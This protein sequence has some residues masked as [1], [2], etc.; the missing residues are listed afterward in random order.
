MNSKFDYSL[1]KR[2]GD[3]TGNGV[4]V[5]D[6]QNKKFLY[7]NE[8][9]LNIFEVQDETLQLDSKIILRYLYTEDFDYLKSRSEE[10]LT[11]GSLST[12]EFRL[13]MPNNVTKHLSC[14]VIAF[15]N[16]SVITA[17]V[18]DVSKTKK[19]EDFLIKYT[20]QKDIM[21]DMLTHNLSG[22][23]QLSKDVI[24]SMQ[25]GYSENKMLDVS[26]LI[27]IMQ[28]NTQQCIDI[29][30]DFLRE[31]HFESSLT[32]VRKTRFDVIDK[33]NIML[34][35]LKEINKE[36][37]FVLK[38][39]LENLYINSDAVKFFQIIHNVLSNSIKFT[40]PNGV[41]EIAV[42][43]DNDFYIVEIK[44]DGI[45]IPQEMHHLIFQDRVKGRTG[46]NGEKSK[47]LGLSIA[48]RLVKIMGG[49]IGFESC[50]NEGC[51]FFIRLPKE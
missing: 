11:S 16:N 15:E 40:N 1:I 25:K 17:F 6:T 41:I 12:T 18:K 31:E 36:K 47:G 44:D 45:G 43:V 29:V 32:Y 48:H 5:Y 2:V 13:K 49:E 34:I 26:K 20:A 3:L 38:S 42:K 10:L 19:H 50:E 7:A 46:L 33:I 9:F 30:N 39:E 27:C 4:V 28:E 14:E 24:T 35:K 23:L 37:V 21:L 8:N 22:P 51:T